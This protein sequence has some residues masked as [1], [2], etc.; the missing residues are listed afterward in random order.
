MTSLKGFFLL[1]LELGGVGALPCSTTAPLKFLSSCLS[2]RVIEG[3]VAIYEAFYISDFIHKIPHEC[4]IRRVSVPPY[5]A[6][7][8]ASC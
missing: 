2:A 1:V 5:A 4:F 6:E 8:G 3:P 7:D